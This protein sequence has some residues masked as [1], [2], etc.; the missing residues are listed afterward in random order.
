MMTS[1]NTVTNLGPIDRNWSTT[2]MKRGQSSLLYGNGG[3]PR[4]NLASSMKTQEEVAQGQVL[5]AATSAV[6]GH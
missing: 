4:N 3:G 6:T 5:I 1:S 2:S